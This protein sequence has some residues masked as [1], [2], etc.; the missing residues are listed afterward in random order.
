M[1]VEVEGGRVYNRLAWEQR[2]GGGGD[3]FRRLGRKKFLQ[4]VA[5]D[6]ECC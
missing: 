1:I 2:S 5:I 6:E 4:L 3:L